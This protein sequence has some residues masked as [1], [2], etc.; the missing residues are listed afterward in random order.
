MLGAVIINFNAVTLSGA[1]LWLAVEEPKLCETAPGW[2][3]AA[4]LISDGRSGKTPLSRKLRWPLS[5]CETLIDSD[6]V[7]RMRF[8]HRPPPLRSG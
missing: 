3:R 6:G 7:F 5:P 1:P 8:A 4:Q 2:M